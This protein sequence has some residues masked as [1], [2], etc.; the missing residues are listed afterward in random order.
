MPG[1]LRNSDAAVRTMPGAPS[2]TPSSLA[3]AR[4]A[5]LWA[6][7]FPMGLLL[8]MGALFLHAQVYPLAK[9]ESLILFSLLALAGAMIGV[10]MHRGGRVVQALVAGILLTVFLNHAVDWPVRNRYSLP[11][12]F[13]IGFGLSWLLGRNFHVIGAAGSL[14]VLLATLALPAAAELSRTSGSG[15]AAQAQP[16]ASRPPVLHLILDGHIGIESLPAGMTG[17]ATMKKQLRDF[18]AEQGFRLYGGAFSRNSFTR[19]AIPDLLN[20]GTVTRDGELI[21]FGSD[22]DYFLQ[23]SEYFRRMAA[24]GYRVHVYQSDV[25]DFCTADVTT[26]NVVRFKSMN[27]I[28]DSDLPRSEKVDILLTVFSNRSIFYRKAAELYNLARDELSARA[29]LHLSP[30]SIAPVL[31]T[32]VSTLALAE[33]LARDMP[34]F[35]AGDLVFAHLMIPHFPFALDTQCQQRGAPDTWFGKTRAEHYRLYL[36][37]V[38]C[39]MQVQSQIFARVNA[40]TY[41]VVHGD[42]GARIL[43]NDNDQFGTLFAVR[44]PD[45][46]ADYVAT[47]TATDELLVREVLEPIGVPVPPLAV[48]GRTIK[49][50]L[51]LGEVLELDSIADFSE[52]DSSSSGK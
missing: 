24:F 34:R 25:M 43:S 37:Q 17:S 40:G 51:G 28:A 16:I 50:K 20:F 3:A 31:Y 41:V 45:R 2:G 33:R 42:H 4:W 18:Y 30:V 49:R 15:A 8:A 5:P 36:E 13:L 29:G 47:M 22:W 35:G 26:C 39:A 27:W 6:V 44:R 19:N 9:F 32:P 14:A 21:R 1:P 11:A 48:A 38:V 52:A 12:S 23:K 46:P 10:L 7:L